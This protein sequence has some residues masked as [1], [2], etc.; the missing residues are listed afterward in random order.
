MIV[1]TYR[2]VGSFLDTDLA[3]ITKNTEAGHSELLRPLFRPLCNGRLI[4]GCS[5]PR[6]TIHWALKAAIAASRVIPLQ[7][8][9]AIAATL[10]SAKPADAF[11]RDLA[12][13]TRRGG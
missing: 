10:R 8:N 6:R 3:G 13:N 5:H 12:A 7:D 9:R 4:K 2:Q 11:G 1:F